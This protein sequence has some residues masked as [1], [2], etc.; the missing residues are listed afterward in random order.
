MIAQG[1]GRFL[2][3][4]RD[5]AFVRTDLLPEDVGGVDADVDVVDM[6]L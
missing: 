1:T 6:I 3:G 2:T 4:F 5:G